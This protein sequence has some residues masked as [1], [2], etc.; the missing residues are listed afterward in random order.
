[1]SVLER[2][3]A[4]YEREKPRLLA[5]GCEGKHVL[6][7]GEQIEGI[8]DTHE[9]GLEAGYRRF[10]VGTPFFVHCIREHEPI[11]A[12]HTPFIVQCRT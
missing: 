10:G 1:M 8:F 5:E 3:Y 7:K 9:Q 12:I 2:E 4:F 6:I 11:I